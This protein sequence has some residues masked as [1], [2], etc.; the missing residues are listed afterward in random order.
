MHL[1]QRGV[2]HGQQ[3]E[4]A[5]LADI[6]APRPRGEGVA[7][8][9]EAGEVLAAGAVGPVVLDRHPVVAF[10]RN[11]EVSGRV[12]AEQPLVGGDDQEVGPNGRDVEGQ[13]ADGLGSVHH[14]HRA[15]LP[16]ARAD[17]FEV[18]ERSVRPVRVRERRHRDPLVQG[19]QDAA[20]PV[21]VLGTREGPD[22]RPALPG[23]FP[24]RVDVGREL[25][26]EEQH[27]PPGRERHVA[28]RGGDA[29]ARRGHQGD[30]V[31]GGADE[32]GE[33][34]APLFG[35]REEVFGDDLPGPALAPGRCLAHLPHH[36]HQ[37]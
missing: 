21:V 37:G 20:G 2:G 35:I 9:D 22:L 11:V 16:A 3:V 26:L 33:E 17:A 32:V 10:R 8:V 12:G 24:P 28:R 25:L 5:A 30:V 15:H 29:V 13:G 4:V 23:P 36:V 34:A 1:P 6:V 18:D 27:L 19:F 14:Q 31:R 7:V